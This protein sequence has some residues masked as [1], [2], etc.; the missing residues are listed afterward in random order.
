MAVYEQQFPRAVKPAPEPLGWYVRPSH[1][2]HRGIADTLASGS[3]GLH[4]VIFDPLH[5][6]RH[7][8]LHDLV[9]EKDRDAILDPRTQELGLPGGFNERL[10]KLPWAMDRQHSPGDF[11]E[12]NARRIA[13]AIAQYAISNRYTSVLAPTHY[14]E[15]ANSPWLDVDVRSTFYLRSYLDKAG[16]NKVPIFYSL[17]ISYEAFRNKEERQVIIQKLAGLPIQSL[18]V[19]VSQSGNLTH[20]GVRNLVTGA[21]DFHSLGVPLIG[22]MAGGLRGLSALAFGAFGGVAHGV[23]QKESFNAGS[24]LKPPKPESKGFVLP[25]RVYVAPLDLHLKKQDAEA[26]FAARNA[27]SRF[28]CHD[29]GCFPRGPQDMFDN[30]IRHGLIQRSAEIQRLSSV[31]EQYRAQRFLEDVLRPA[32]DAAVFAETLSF[33]GHEKLER[34]MKEKRRVLDRL[35]IGLGKFVD[36]GHIVSF[37]QVPQRRAARR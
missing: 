3:I 15:S 1:I 9:L 16:G 25:P 18:W 29:R 23:T 34:Q 12:V 13:D 35:R 32:T 14:I 11:D 31:P 24:W 19:K 7:A 27:K 37:S 8:E 22:D 6:G 2:D 5:E 28:G 26:F 17:A 33:G 4:G 10:A 21:A 20:A 30:P 36:D